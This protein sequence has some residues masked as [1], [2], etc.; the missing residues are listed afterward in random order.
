M[1]LNQLYIKLFTKQKVGRQLM[2]L[3]TFTLIPVLLVCYIAYGISYRQLTENY[4]HLIEARANQVRSVIVSTTLYLHDIYETVAADTELR[5]L[6]SKDYETARDAQSALNGY[7]E[8]RNAL[9]NTA[10]LS[11]L[12]LYVDESVLGQDSPFTYY[13]PITSQVK[14]SNWYARASQT[15][16]NFWMSN[17]RTGQAGVEYWELNYYCHIPIPQTSSYAILVMSVSNDFLRNLIQNEGYEIYASVNSDP[18]FFSSNRQYAGNAFPISLEEGAGRYS[19]TGVTDVL[20][21]EIMASVQTLIPYSTSD[22]I[23][24][25]AAD[26]LALD[27]IHHIR[28][29]FIFITLFA[30][31]VSVLLIYLFSCY[32]STRIQTLRLAMNKVS[33]NDYEI[34]N[35]IQGDDELSATFQDLKSMVEKLKETEAKIYQAQINEQIISNQQ[36]QMEL[37]LLANQIN[38]HFLYNTLETIRMKAFAEGN[39]EVATAI[40]L[41]GKSMR[42]VLNNTKTAATT[43]DKEIDYIRTYL[44]I[45]KLRFAERLNY[46]IR[47]VEPLDLTAYQILPL[48]IQPIVENAI[49][50]GLEDTGKVGHVILKLYKSGDDLLVADVFDNGIGMDEETLQRV[51]ENLSIPQ[52]ESEHG[53]GLYNINNRVR[54]FYGASYG[55]TIKSRPDYGT[56]VTLTI[57]LHN[58]TEEEA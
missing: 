32:F 24:I 2:T 57:P 26:P 41:L 12:K 51:T 50:H 37:K 39:R 15:K 44:S 52:P 6:L 16:G 8:F 27:N 56:L 9:E 58:L 42:Y 10:S 49:S 3:F 33:N 36:Q 28:N 23:Y 22:N 14:E 34:V 25:L 38:P 40:K 45:Q 13:Y 54:L 43:L 53:V 17:T 46:T 18:A 20:G 21:T 1:K 7:T 19:Y 11:S 48:L 55:L 47:I 4:E 30:L 5:D 29:I 31:L 35:S